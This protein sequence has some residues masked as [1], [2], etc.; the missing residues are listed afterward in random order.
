[1]KIAV[2][3]SMTFSKK[4]LDVE[5]ELLG[6][7]HAVILPKFTKEYSILETADKIHAESAENKIEHDLIKDYFYEIK[8]SDAIL[9]INEDKKDIKNYIGGNSLIEIA[10]A[11]ILG[12]KIFL[13]NPI[14]Q[15]N[16]IDEIV[17]M[18]PVVLNGNL[19]KIL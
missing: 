8:N 5:R 16:Y 11:H 19:T 2:C 4:M 6:L 13:M 14:P 17:A 9:V 1:M 12:K 10:F 7:K 15:M 3:G 18:K